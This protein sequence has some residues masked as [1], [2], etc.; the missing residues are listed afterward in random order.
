MLKMMLTVS[1]VLILAATTPF[2]HICRALSQLRLPGVICLQLLLTYRY[3]AVLIGEM[4]R[5]VTAYRLRSPLR[6]GIHIRH[7]G[8]FLGALLLRSLGRA[9]RVYQAM[10]CRG[11]D[12]TWDWIRA[13]R[14]S[15]S[16]ML[17][18]IIIIA[19]CALFR[20]VNLSGMIGSLFV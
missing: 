20:F 10:L 16:A 13:T 19:L 4:A 15:A 18:A 3:I 12:G 7:V 5:A 6:S 11:F 14:V 9:E 1:A 17:Y 8:S 2:T